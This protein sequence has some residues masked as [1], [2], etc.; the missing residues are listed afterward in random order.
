MKAHEIAD[1]F[2][3]GMNAAFAVVVDQLEQAPEDLTAREAGNRFRAAQPE[4]EAR[5]VAAMD[6]A[7]AGVDR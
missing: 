2:R 6:Q 7:A 3:S 1:A 4:M 5:L